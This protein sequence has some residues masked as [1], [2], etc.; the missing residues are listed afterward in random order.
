MISLEGPSPCGSCC[1]DLESWLTN[2]LDP[3]GTLKGPFDSEAV[4]KDMIESWADM[5]EPLELSLEDLTELLDLYQ[6]AGA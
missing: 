5:G 3:N 4:A 1:C 6:E 2:H